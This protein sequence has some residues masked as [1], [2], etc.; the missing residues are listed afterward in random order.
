[1]RMLKYFLLNYL[2]SVALTTQLHGELRDSI[3]ATI[4]FIIISKICC[5]RRTLH[6]WSHCLWNVLGEAYIILLFLTDRDH[7]DECEWI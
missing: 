5:Y 2:I 3:E 1:M 4:V 7:G 6:S